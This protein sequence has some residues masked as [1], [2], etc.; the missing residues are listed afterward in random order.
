MRGKL[1]PVGSRVP[2][3]IDHERPEFPWESC[4]RTQFMGSGTEALS[5]AIALSVKL[6]PGV[7]SPEAIIPAY[8]CPDLVAAIISQ[9]VKP[10]L[11]DLKPDS[12]WMSA[13]AVSKAVSSSTVAIVGVGFLGIPERF[14]SL[15]RVCRE[16][17]LLLVEDSAQCFLPASLSDPMADCVVLSFGR[18]KPVNLM[19][20]GALLFRNDSTKAV[21]PLLAKYPLELRKTG[22]VWRLKRWM[23]NLLLGRTGYKVLELL[24]LG[25]GETHF[26]EL[27]EIRRLQINEELLTAGIQNCCSRPHADVQYDSELSELELFG[28]KL[29]TKTCKREPS[30]LRR[31]FMLRYPVLAPSRD[32][33]DRALRDLNAAGIGANAL[34]GRILPDI[35]GVD[36]H[37]MA[38]SYP[39]ASDFAARLLTLPTHEDVK[40]SDIAVARD[41]LIALARH[42]SDSFKRD[43]A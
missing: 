1:R 17:N 12:P 28:W 39:M 34:Y 13:S 25:I 10:V 16:H 14:A 41:V 32:I 27:H 40:V 8:G 26:H 6:K 4:Y 11:A 19:G 31:R 9:G 30:E 18:G 3:P 21:E 35:K 29:L 37:V 36:A 22:L 5:V 20:G 24:P 23:I 42:E 2:M 15:L 7:S 43:S 38:G 33:R